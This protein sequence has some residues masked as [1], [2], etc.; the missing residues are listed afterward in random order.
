[1]LVLSIA[2]HQDFQ[3]GNV[4]RALH[5]VK[6]DCTDKRGWLEVHHPSDGIL[7]RIWYEAYMIS[8]HIVQ[9]IFKVHYHTVGRL[10]M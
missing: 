9:Q 6:G 4:L 10:C 7:S 8:Q 2:G 3:H 1:M 5:E